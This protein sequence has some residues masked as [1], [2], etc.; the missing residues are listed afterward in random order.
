MK[1]NNFVILLA[2]ALLT[3]L[4]IGCVPDGPQSWTPVRSVPEYASS[5]L[6]ETN[7]E[8]QTDPAPTTEFPTESLSTEPPRPETVS[9]ESATEPVNVTVYSSE[10]AA[11]T[12]EPTTASERAGLTQPEN[13]TE[14]D[15]EEDSEV[16]YVAN[17]NTRKFHIPTCSSVT[18]MKESNKLYFFGSRDELIEKGYEPCKRCKP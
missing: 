6:P 14:A 17:K 15:P 12:V 3:V 4:L 5:N 7:D 1:R 13:S 18:D 2:A 9:T 10:I 11:E 8:A 16:S